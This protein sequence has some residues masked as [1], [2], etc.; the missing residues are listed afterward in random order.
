[1]ESFI[2]YFT[3]SLHLTNFDINY[4][5]RISDGHAD[6]MILSRDRAKIYTVID[7]NGER[8]GVVGIFY[9]DNKPFTDVSIDPKYRGRGLLIEFYRLLA[10][11]LNLS[12][13]WAYINNDNIASIKAHEKIGFK[14]AKKVYNKF[15]YVLNI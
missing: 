1:M 15:V 8:L 5:E 6:L 4:Y 12:Q 2:E 7:D 9:Y 11:E 3:E 10:K 13:L 14:K